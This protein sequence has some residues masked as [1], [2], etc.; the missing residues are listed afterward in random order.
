MTRQ[1]II[2]FLGQDWT[3]MQTCI[4]SGLLSDVVLLNDTNNKLLS[5]SGKLV[6]PMICLLLCRAMGEV[7]EDS[8]HYAA[9][10]ELLHNATL[11]HDDVTDQSM[12]RRGHPTVAAMLGPSA[13]VLVGD[14]WLA[15][16]VDLVLESKHFAQVVRYFSRTLNDLAEGEM[17]Q[18]QKASTADTSEEDYFRIIGG[19]TASLFEVAGVSASMSIAAC[20]EYALAAKNFARN[21]GIAFQIKDDILDYVGDQML[22]KPVGVDLREQKITL[23]LLGAMQNVGPQQE[24]EMREMIRNIHKDPSYVERISQFVAQNAGIEY[25]AIRLQEY[26]DRAIDDLNVFPDSQAKSYLAQI[27]QFNA[28]RTI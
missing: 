16:A 1:E 21:F 6:R 22:G 14:F 8:Y 4:K 26:I 11:M 9:A 25:A 10:C 12:E 20:D 2:D 15:R 17:L 13:A 3:N 5:H 24:G 19:K 18:M 7:N 27:A 23:P 28:I